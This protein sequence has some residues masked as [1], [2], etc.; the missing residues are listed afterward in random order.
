MKW[1]TQSLT[2]TR[3]PPAAFEAFT[4]LLPVL[5][6]TSSLSSARLL[7]VVTAQCCMSILSM[8]FVLLLELLDCVHGLKVIWKDDEHEEQE[9]HIC[10]LVSLS[11]KKCLSQSF[12]VFVKC[13]IVKSVV[14]YPV[15]SVY[16][17]LR[18]SEEA[19]RYGVHRGIFHLMAA[20]QSRHISL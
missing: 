19:T 20:G 2:V 16:I 17:V 15:D 18:M 12:R 5:T 9:Q 13:E 11:I 14:D 10:R 8:S 6:E 1:Q 3:R 4:V 7:V